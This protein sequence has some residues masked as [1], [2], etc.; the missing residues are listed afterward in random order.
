MEDGRNH[1]PVERQNGQH[2]YSGNRPAEQ[3][4]QQ[5][6]MIHVLEQ[7]PFVRAA[8]HVQPAVLHR[9]NPQKNLPVVNG[10][11]EFLRIDSGDDFPGGFLPAVQGEPV[12]GAVHHQKAGV[13]LR[14]GFSP[15]SERQQAL[16]HRM[17]IAGAQLAP[18][19]IADI[20]QHLIGGNR[21]RL[22]QNP[23]TFQIDRIRMAFQDAFQIP[24]PH[25][26]TVPVAAEKA[27][28]IQLGIN[29]PDSGQIALYAAVKLECVGIGLPAEIILNDVAVLQVVHQGKR[30]FVGVFQLFYKLFSSVVSVLGALL[31]NDLSCQEENNQICQQNGE[32]SRRQDGRQLLTDPEPLEILRC[33]HRSS[34]FREHLIVYL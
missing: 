7:E 22:L 4:V 14:L 27:N 24:I 3:K 26:G 28:V 10:P 30:L 8:D 33:P 9:M 20:D 11:G 16:P 13:S 1:A 15:K 12:K 6:H 23:V 32:D 25:G 5:K 17:G 19:I 2:Q 21:T 18:V 29:Q 31:Q 34:P